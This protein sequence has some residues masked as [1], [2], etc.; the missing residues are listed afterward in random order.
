MLWDAP[1]PNRIFLPPGDREPAY[2][3]FDPDMLE[4]SVMWPGRA[5]RGSGVNGHAIRPGMGAMRVHPSTGLRIADPQTTWV[6]LAG[7]LPHPYDLVAVADHF[8]RVRRPRFHRPSESVDPPLATIGQLAE[9]IEAGRRRGGP[10]LRAALE[11]VRT[12]SASR[13][14]TW[15]RLTLI[16][17]G[18]PEP[19]LDVDVF[20]G[21]GRWLGRVDMTYPQWRI[22]V[23]YEG[24]HHSAG[25]Q[26]ESDIDRY[27]RLEQAGWKVIRVTRR[28][29]FQFPETIAQR[30]RA[31]IAERSS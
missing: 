8:V 19:A 5:P 24:I 21:E 22:A 28:M 13:T 6:M 3:L 12:G 27:A 2:R 29:L 1:V 25:G 23:E 15:T 26:W 4:V 31:A 20:D 11:R 7:M 9:A 30:V 10:Q 16:D 14:E 18:L 17:A